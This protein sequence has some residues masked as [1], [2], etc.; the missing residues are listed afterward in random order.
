[1]FLVV[2]TVWILTQMTVMHSSLAATLPI[3]PAHDSDILAQLVRVQQE[4]ANLRDAVNAERTAQ[5][6]SQISSITLLDDVNVE[7]TAQRANQQSSVTRIRSGSC[8]TNL[9][10]LVSYQYDITLSAVIRKLQPRMSPNAKT[11]R[12]LM[13]L[14]NM[15]RETMPDSQ[16]WRLADRMPTIV[17]RIDQLVAEV[18]C[19]IWAQASCAVLF[20]FA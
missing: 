20:R 1:M 10:Q 11:Q 19:G 2:L 12:A 7:R 13:S 17:Q 3:E 9:D 6:A 5:R 18:G 4:I 8:I 14:V 16:R 15:T